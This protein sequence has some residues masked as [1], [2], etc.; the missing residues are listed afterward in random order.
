MNRIVLA[1]HGQPDW[2]RDTPIAGSEMAKWNKGR[3]NAPLD[4]ESRPSKRL[5]S[6]AKNSHLIA[7]S[8]LRRSIDSAKL[9][10]PGRKPH[11]EPLFRE[12]YLPTAIHSRAKLPPK[13]WSATLRAAWHLGWSPGVESHKEAEARAILAAEELEKLAQRHHTVLLIGHGM[14]NG[15]IGR[16]L[17]RAGWK[18]PV[19]RAR[20]HWA[21]TVYKKSSVGS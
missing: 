21:Y 7:T 17:R 2:D 20:K 4:P 10:A 14:M 8:E 6:F 13:V 19:L 5:V 11:V 12:V 15:L 9:L 1:R 3:D 16:N 18:G